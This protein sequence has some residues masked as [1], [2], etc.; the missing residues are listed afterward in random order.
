MVNG[1]GT[2]DD[3]DEEDGGDDEEDDVIKKVINLT[4][5]ANMRIIIVI[6][7]I[8]MI[9][10]KLRTKLTTMI[11]I[12]ELVFSRKPLSQPCYVSDDGPLHPRGVL[13][14]IFTP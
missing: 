1:D 12:S 5:K 4:I 9:I 13:S 8:I 7:N 11:K 14:S 3:Y 6:I 10:M 2:Y